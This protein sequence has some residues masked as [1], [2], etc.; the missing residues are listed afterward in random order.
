MEKKREKK[1]ENKSEKSTINWYPGHMTRALRSMKKD[2]SL[3][4]LVIELTDARAVCSSMNPDIDRLCQGKGRLVLINKSDL[5][6]E[7]INSL[8]KKHFT[9]QG[10]TCLIVNSKKGVKLKEI[11]EAARLCCRSIIERNRRRGIAERPLRAMVAGIPNVGKSTLINR[12]AGRNIARA[13]NKPGVTRGNQWITCG[14]HLE[15]LD[16]PG[17]LWPKFTDSSTGYALSAI[18]SIDD[19]VVERADLAEWLYSFLTASYPGRCAN[20]YGTDESSPFHEALKA[21]A[22]S[23][24]AVQG[25]GEA[26]LDRALSI[27]VEDFRNGRLGR[28]SLERPEAAIGS[29]GTDG[30]VS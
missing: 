2:I 20:V 23:R 18:G 21:V 28:I 10:T 19:H 29:A 14:K 1:T 9:D 4:D 13:A 30:G 8:W 5:A 27:F 12:Y 17:I 16:T 7:H 26:D 22:K 3:V 24:G 11:D 15:L 6:D 25:G